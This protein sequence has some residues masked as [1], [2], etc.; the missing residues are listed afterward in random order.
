MKR[1]K[2]ELH[3]CIDKHGISSREALEISRELDLLIVK[4]QRS[5]INRNNKNNSRCGF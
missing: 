5:M 3:R 2:R 4:E 1:L